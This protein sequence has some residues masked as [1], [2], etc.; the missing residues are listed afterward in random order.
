MSVPSIDF[1]DSG[2]KFS[3]LE[4]SELDYLIG[5]RQI[6]T[7]VPINRARLIHPSGVIRVLAEF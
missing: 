6:L 1:P 3:E 4:M 7:S 2:F 5:F